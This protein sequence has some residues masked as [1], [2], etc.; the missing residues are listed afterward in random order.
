MLTLGAAGVAIGTRFLFAHES[1][2]SSVQKDVLIEAGLINST[3]RTLAFD[4][5]GGTNGW[6]PKHNGRAIKNKII[7][8][9]EN[10]LDFNTRLK[11]Y[12]ESKND[13]DTSRLISWAGVGVGL[14]N[15]LASAEVGDPATTE[16]FWSNM[17]DFRES[18]VNYRKRRY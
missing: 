6:P 17:I 13:G 9:V 3:V 11:R 18:C 4:E 1:A 7:E 16:V 8:D 14:T 12:E 15:T 10:G 5:V 2:Y